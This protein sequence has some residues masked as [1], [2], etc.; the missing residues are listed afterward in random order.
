MSGGKLQYGMSVLTEGQRLGRIASSGSLAKGGMGAVYEAGR[1]RWTSGWRSRPCM[2]ITRR[3]KESIARFFN[4]AKVLSRLEHPE[5]R[6]GVRLQLHAA[7]GT[8]YLVMEYLRGQSL[9]SR[10]R[11]TV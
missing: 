9:A 8:A 1:N 2:R 11:Q 5:H 7:D 3:T 4:E 6:A 10:A